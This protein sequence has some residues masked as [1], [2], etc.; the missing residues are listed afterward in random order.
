[1]NFRFDFRSS[2]ADIV[3]PTAVRVVRPHNEQV[4]RTVGEAIALIQSLPE[5]TQHKDRWRVALDLL[6]DAHQKRYIGKLNNARTFLVEAIR[7]EN[8]LSARRS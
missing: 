7:A 6:R 8:W 1:M 5:A 4:L 2:R 3:L